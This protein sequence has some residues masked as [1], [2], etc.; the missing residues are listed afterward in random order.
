MKMT[1]EFKTRPKNLSSGLA[2]IRLNTSIGRKP[3]GCDFP[4][5]SQLKLRCV[6]QIPATRMRNKMRFSGLTLALVLLMPALPAL[7]QAG[8]PASAP[9]DAKAAFDAQHLRV[10]L[11]IPGSKLYGGKQGNLAGLY[12]KLEPGWHVYW[13]NAGDAGEPPGINW[14]L[15]EGRYRRTVAVSGAAA[16]ACWAADGLRLR[17]RRAVSVQ[18]AR[19]PEREDRHGRARRQG[20]LAGVQLGLHSGQSRT[21][22]YPRRVARRGAGRLAVPPLFQHFLSTLPKPLP[23][24]VIRPSSRP[25]PRASALPSIRDSG[26]RRPSSFPSI[27]RWWTTPP[28]KS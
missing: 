3:S 19:G 21:A 16:A 14:T 2:P 15:P 11:L 27:R 9:K 1:P 22:D 8:A 20:E 25:R 13:Q 7:A 6:E 18:A 23:G 17:G 24:G 10:E 26:K 12:F 28:R 5:S 4:D